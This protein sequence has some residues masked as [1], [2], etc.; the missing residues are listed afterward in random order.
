MVR[1]AAQVM[2]VSTAMLL[3]NELPLALFH[4]DFRNPQPQYKERCKQKLKFLNAEELAIQNW[5]HSQARTWV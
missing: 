3:S 4:E 2:N 5:Y 1:D